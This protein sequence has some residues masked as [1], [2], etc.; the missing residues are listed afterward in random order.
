MLKESFGF[1]SWASS[2]AARVATAAVIMVS[3]NVL[4]QAEDKP[5]PP[6]KPKVD[7]VGDKQKSANRNADAIRA[8]L[9]VPSG[10]H[11]GPYD[12]LFALGQ[13]AV[14]FAQPPSSANSKTDN[15]IH[16]WQD[17]SMQWTSSS[18][19]TAGVKWA[20]SKGPSDKAF[21]SGYAPLSQSHRDGVPERF[22]IPILNNL[23]SLPDAS[24]D[25]V[26]YYIRVSP[27]NAGM[28]PIGLPSNIAKVTFVKAN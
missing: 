25:T 24:A 2:A 12:Q 9:F 27:V 1:C 5:P 21:L 16:Q 14:A 6:P 11:G 4:A 19:N 13:T 8:L 22:T 26:V 17:L 3:C 28:E 18:K 10:N 7:I 15:I 20:I 23:Q